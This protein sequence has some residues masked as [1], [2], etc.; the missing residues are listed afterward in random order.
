MLSEKDIAWDDFELFIR[1]FKQ[2]KRLEIWAK[3]KSSSEFYPLIN[4][5][6]CAGSGVIG[7]KRKEGD[8]QIPEGVYFIDRFNPN[9][10]FHLS[11]GLNYPNSADVIHSDPIAPGSDIFIHGGCQ[12][13]GCI[14][15]TNEKIEELYFLAERAKALG[16]EK[17]YVYIF[18]SEM[19]KSF[20][21]QNSSSPYL[22]FWK[23]LEKIHEYFQ[24]GHFLPTIKSNE[25]GEYIIVE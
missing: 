18:P 4:Y 9:S 16:Q 17:I 2:E 25:D 14:A 20:F 6:F 3:S 13:I 1:A 5:P 8:R 7:P 15:I 22:S 11:L 23:N 19:D 21:Q 10:K 24:E 12:S